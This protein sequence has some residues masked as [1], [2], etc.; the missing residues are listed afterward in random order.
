MDILLNEDSLRGQYTND[1]FSEY[2]IETMI[3]CLELMDSKLCTIYKKSDI[4]GQ[5]V[6]KQNTLYDFLV[7]RGDPVI[8]KFKLYLHRMCKTEPFWDTNPV[9]NL[10]DCYECDTI[11]N[12]IPNCISEAYERNGILYSFLTHEY[13]MNEVALIKNGIQSSIR[14][15]YDINSLKN[16]MSQLGLIEIWSANSFPIVLGYKF[17]I[18]FREDN[19][20]VAHFHISKN[21]A[22][23]S[24]DILKLTKIVG[25][26]P[27]EDEKAILN[28]ADEHYEQ[29]KE[30]WNR[31]H[32]G[33][34]YI[35]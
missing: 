5:Y 35:E 20:S 33:R 22:S 7:Q 14:N 9:T 13:N 12:E 4:Y 27:T 6:T 16:H 32:A 23:A 17:E 25:E 8:V 19:H 26:I 3:P 15:A 10:E 30:L 28:W 34:I 11:G 18:R 24:Y 21:D 31:Y 29:L 2:M 1:G